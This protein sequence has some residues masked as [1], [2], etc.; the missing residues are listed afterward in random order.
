MMAHVTGT[1][2][3]HSA[4]LHFAWVLPSSRTVSVNRAV[5]KAS[6]TGTVSFYTLIPGI[7]VLGSRTLVGTDPTHVAK[8]TALITPNPMTPS[9]GLRLTIRH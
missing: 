9:S 7:T 4:A 6:A 3:T 8:V 5:A 2:F 1:G